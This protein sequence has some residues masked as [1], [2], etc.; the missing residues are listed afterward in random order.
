MAQKRKNFTDLDDDVI[1]AELCVSCG[2]CVAV[3]PVNVIELEN[4]LPKLIGNCIECGLCWENCPKT[5]LDVN[6]LE[7]KIYGRTRNREEELTGVYRAVYAAKTKR[8]EIHEK[9]QDGGV[10]TSILLQFLEDGGDGVIVASLEEDKIWV[11]KPM[12]AKTKEEVIQSAGTKYTVSSSLL[13]VKQAVKD[14][15]LEKI[16]VVGTPCQ[17]RGLA[18]LTKDKFMNKKFAD[19][20]DLSIGL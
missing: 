20:V 9:A 6:A 19:A 7:E 18:R 12:I 16:A 8:D 15:K 14:E 11:P 4:G 1:R 3:C 2:T 17:M 5:N 13:G 10:V